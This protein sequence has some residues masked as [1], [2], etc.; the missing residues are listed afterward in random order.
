MPKVK[1]KEGILKAAREK[2]I[3]TYKGTSIRLAVDFSKETMQDRR[4][5]HNIFDVMKTQ[6]VQPRIIEGQIKSFPDN[7]K[8]K[9]FII[10]KPVLQ[11][12]LEGLL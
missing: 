11:E 10:I 1:Y 4:A 6:D 9:K 7:N 3:V 12:M 2:H 8:L 5:W